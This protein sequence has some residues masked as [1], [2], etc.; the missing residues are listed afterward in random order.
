MTASTSSLSNV[1]KSPLVTATR[2][3]AIGEPYA[4]AFGI[5]IC[6]SI[7]FGLLIPLFLLRFSTISWSFGFSFSDN[8]RV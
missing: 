5:G 3:P 6:A 8:A 2:V 4:N 1:F 7:N